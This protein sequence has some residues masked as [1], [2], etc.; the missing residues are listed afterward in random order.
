MTTNP[1]AIGFIGVLTYW[2]HIVFSVIAA[3]VTECKET[4]EKR[5]LNYFVS[6]LA[7]LAT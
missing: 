7:D 6:L 5:T 4:L 2:D 1:N 3:T